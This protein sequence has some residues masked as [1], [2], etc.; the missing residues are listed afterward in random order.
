MTIYL[1]AQIKELYEV[2]DK[3]YVEWCK[4]HNKPTSYKKSITEFIYKIRTGRL[5]KDEYGHLQVKKPRKK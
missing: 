1:N 5:V 4:K 2:S 3:D